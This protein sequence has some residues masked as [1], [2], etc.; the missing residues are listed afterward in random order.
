MDGGRGVEDFL[1][2]HGGCTTVGFIAG[3]RPVGFIA[4]A[5]VAENNDAA[6]Q[7]SLA[8]IIG[9]ARPKYGARAEIVLETDRST[10]V[11][12]VTS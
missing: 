6:C 7:R 2:D 4:G 11:S 8:G 12:K 10:V 9:Y 5:I 3:A 1:G